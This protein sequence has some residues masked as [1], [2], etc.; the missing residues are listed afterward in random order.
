M[1]QS[2][3]KMYND[4]IV[5]FQES[6]T[7]LNACTKTSGNLLKAPRISAEFPCR[8]FECSFL[9]LSLSFWLAAFSL[10]SMCS[11]FRS[12]YLL[13]AMLIVI[14]SRLSNFTFY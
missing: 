2:S 14:D 11:T 12:L 13:S 4:N 8:F 9:F 7:I 3:R 1:C 5:N 6:M 10:L